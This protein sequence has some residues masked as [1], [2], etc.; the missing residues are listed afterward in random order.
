MASKSKALRKF[1]KAMDACTQHPD[2]THDR[3]QLRAAYDLAQQ[4]LARTAPYGRKLTEAQA[5]NAAKTLAE[6]ME[7]PWDLMPEEG[8]ASMREHARAIVSASYGGETPT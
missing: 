4:A 7:Y 2:T 1:I 6:R 3:D 8:R 5:E